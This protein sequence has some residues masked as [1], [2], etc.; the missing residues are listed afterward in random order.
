MLGQ[1]VRLRR[2][3]GG[4]FVYSLGI[5]YITQIV[6]LTGNKDLLV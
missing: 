4:S 6:I 3:L 5:T 2:W 1:H